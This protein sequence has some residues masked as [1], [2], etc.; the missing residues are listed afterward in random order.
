MKKILVPLDGSK[1]AEEILIHV[2]LLAKQSG[3]QVIGVCQSLINN[4]T[5]REL[6]RRTVIFYA[7]SIRSK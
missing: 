3:A 2:E 6:N 5:Y 1:V 4:Q 7:K